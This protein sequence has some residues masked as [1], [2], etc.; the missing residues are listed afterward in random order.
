MLSAF[1]APMDL[2]VGE[3]IEE[4]ISECNKMSEFL[5]HDHYVTNVRKPTPD[6]ILR[7][8]EEI[9]HGEK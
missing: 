5:F 2:T 3:V 7:Y 6:E 1:F 4:G 8:L 9:G